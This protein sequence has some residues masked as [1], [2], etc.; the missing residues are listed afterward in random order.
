MKAGR[1]S[2]AVRDYQ[3]AMKRRSSRDVGSKLAD[4]RK[5]QRH[6]DGAIIEAR[7]D[8]FATEGRE[9]QAI[10]EWMRAAQASSQVARREDLLRKVGN[11]QSH[12]RRRSVLRRSLL[13]LSLFL[14]VIA[15]TFVLTPMVHNRLSARDLEALSSLPPAERISGIDGFV[16]QA[17]PYAWYVRLFMREYELLTV[18]DAQQQRA[19]LIKTV[20]V[21]PQADKVL[22]DRELT[23]LAQLKVRDEDV[24]VT[25]KQLAADAASVR[26]IVFDPERRVQVDAIAVRAKAGLEAAEARRAALGQQVVKARRTGAEG[27]QVFARD[28]VVAAVSPRDAPRLQLAGERVGDEVRCAVE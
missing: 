25:W 10:D 21:Q 19:D 8:Q 3:E 5:L 4:A 17:K 15:A 26:Q 1:A 18:A 13:L 28:N 16:E 20:V 11:L 14:L 2:S 9:D 23:L 12:K 7:G 27:E 6:E 24:R 22:A